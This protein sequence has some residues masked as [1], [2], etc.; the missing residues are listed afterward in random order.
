MNLGGRVK[1]LV[2]GSFGGD[3]E[4]VGFSDGVETLFDGDAGQML[5]GTEVHAERAD[6]GKGPPTKG[7]QE[8][9]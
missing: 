6:L 3:D 2:E 7:E 4:T 9:N 1:G 5:K 8:R